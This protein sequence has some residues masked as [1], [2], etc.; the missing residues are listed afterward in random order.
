MNDTQIL[1]FL[2]KISCP[3]GIRV[4]RGKQLTGRKEGKVCIRSMGMQR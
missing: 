1:R 2:K 4:N 3:Q